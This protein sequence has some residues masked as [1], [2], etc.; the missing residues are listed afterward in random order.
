MASGNQSLEHV[1]FQLVK[2]ELSAQ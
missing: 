2:P 1:K